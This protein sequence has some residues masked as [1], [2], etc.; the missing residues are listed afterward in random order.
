MHL[1]SQRGLPVVAEFCTWDAWF[2]KYAPAPNPVFSFTPECRDQ[3]FGEHVIS[4]SPGKIDRRA[5]AE[6]RVSPEDPFLRRTLK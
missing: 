3:M 1:I 4:L 2:R 5:L 6:E